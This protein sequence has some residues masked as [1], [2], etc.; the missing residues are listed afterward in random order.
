MDILNIR[1]FQRIDFIDI[2]NEIEKKVKESG[3]MEGICYL[4]V[5]H[6]TA[7]L[8]INENADPAVINDIRLKVNNLI[9]YKDTYTHGEGNS[10]AH[11]KS[12]IFG[13]S[14]NLIISRSRLV[15]GTWQ[16][17]YFCEFDG[18]R[19]RNLYIKILAG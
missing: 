19:N 6:T 2:T 5:P 1:T 8:T 18:P 7:G 11:I 14:L 15:L 17:V 16:G 13:V 3:I 4:F 9:P 12:S 10:D